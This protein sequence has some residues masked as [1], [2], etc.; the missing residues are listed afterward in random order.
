MSLKEPRCVE[1]SAFPQ[2]CGTTLPP[3]MFLS[4]LQTCSGH[5]CDRVYIVDLLI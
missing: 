5:S 2:T 4:V 3:I 1:Y